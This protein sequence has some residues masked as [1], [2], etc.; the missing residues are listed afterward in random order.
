VPG[1]AIGF[2]HSFIHQ[3]AHFLNSLDEKKRTEPTFER[4]HA[5]GES[6][7]CGASIGETGQVGKPW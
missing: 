2:E 6:G 5:G 4:C 1:L 7:E 3:V